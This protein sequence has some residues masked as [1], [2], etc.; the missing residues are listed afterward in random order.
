MPKSIP[1][2][3]IVLLFSPQCFHPLSTIV[4]LPLTFPV[5][6]FTQASASVH[7]SHHQ[8][9]CLHNKLIM[10]VKVK[11]SVGSVKKKTHTVILEEKN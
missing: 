10:E 6:L 3:H 1:I 2:L 11:T 8:K 5:Q 4:S 9:Q 7:T